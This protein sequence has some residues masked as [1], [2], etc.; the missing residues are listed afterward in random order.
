MVVSVKP[1]VIVERVGDDLMVIV[2]GNSD[3]VKLTGGVAEVLLDISAGKS[4][5]LSDP[6][7]VD[8]LELGI[9]STPGVSRRGLIKAGAIGAGAGI[10][11]LAMP[12]VAAAS[13][14]DDS[15]GGVIPLTQ[16]GDPFSNPLRFDF[17]AIPPTFDDS[18]DLNSV[19]P[20]IETSTVTLSNGDTVTDAVT[21][22]GWFDGIIFR[23]QTNVP[24]STPVTIVAAEVQFLFKGIPWTA[25]FQD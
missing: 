10:A 6:A 19:V 23:L 18:D 13:S 5:D 11:V 9:V 1:G 17:Q 12:S 15:D 4:V 3:V 25:R 21:F 16:F 24:S 14:G 8:L 22:Q 7:V 20:T 2:P